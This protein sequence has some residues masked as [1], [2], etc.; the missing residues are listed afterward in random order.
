[1]EFV[2]HER[3]ESEG[4]WIQV[5]DPSAPAKHVGN[6]DSKASKCNDSQDD[7][8]CGRHSLRECA[9][10]RGNCS[11]QHGHDKRRDEADKDEEEEWS[12]LASKVRHE[13]KDQ[14]EEDRVQDLVW[15]VS[16]H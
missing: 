5:V 11:E 15:H 10:H 6:R 14:V 7:D 9:G 12:G 13:V 2:N 16:E 1:V 4:D 8:R 3:L